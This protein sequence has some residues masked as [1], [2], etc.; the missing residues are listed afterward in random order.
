M[1]ESLTN[2]LRHA[3]ATRASVR[4]RVRA[5]QLEIAVEDDGTGG[6]PVGRASGFA[7]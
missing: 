6:P 1:Q 7:A 2:V 4:V 5:G 3:D